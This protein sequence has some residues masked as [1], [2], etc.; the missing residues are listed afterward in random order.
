[1][2]AAAEA[3]R[4]E[5]EARR[6]L[7]EARNRADAIIYQT[8]SALAEAGENLPAALRQDVTAAIE[9]ARAAAAEE[10]ADAITAA[11]NALHESARQIGAYLYTATASSPPPAPD[12]GEEDV[13]DGQYTAA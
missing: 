3:H 13:V 10:D 2:M 1:M 11:T 4:Q 12:A 6:A 8:E 5:D 7:I 9:A